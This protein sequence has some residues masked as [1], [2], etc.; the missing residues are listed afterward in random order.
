MED[1]VSRLWDKYSENSKRYAR[2]EM[3]L[4]WFVIRAEEYINAL[5]HH[6]PTMF[7]NYPA[8]IGGEKGLVS[9]QFQQVIDALKILFLDTLKLSWTSDFR[10]SDLY[11]LPKV[12]G[13]II[14]P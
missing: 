14:Q 12:C 4:R 11:D 6:T 2:S 13:K 3:V 5:E 10:W 7:E 1:A 8:R 9:W